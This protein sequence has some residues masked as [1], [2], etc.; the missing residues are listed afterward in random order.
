MRDERLVRAGNAFVIS[1]PVVPER[2]ALAVFDSAEWRDGGRTLGERT[3][4]GAVN[5]LDRGGETW[6]LRH[7]YRGGLV[8]RFVD[9][10]YIWTGLERT[11]PFREWRLLRRLRHL[12]LPV[13][14]PVAA[15]VSRAG[16]VYRGDIVTRLLP[17]TRPLSALLDDTAATPGT[18]AEIGRV[19]RRFHDH[20]VQHP[21]LTAHNILLNADGR[22]FLVD[23]DNARL[24]PPGPWRKAGIARLERSLRKVAL[25][26]GTDFDA[27]GWRLLVGGY[28]EG[29]A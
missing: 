4:R 15:R 1:D 14:S 25:E 16:L 23:F 6:V 26:T 27:E 20:G 28:A 5:V 18:W 10:H 21:D 7:Y 8:S 29:V 2:D 11:R 12:D 19:L 17:E 24:R 9:D 22:I 13:P 3:G